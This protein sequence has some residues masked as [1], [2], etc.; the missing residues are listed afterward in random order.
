MLRRPQMCQQHLL[1]EAEASS[2]TQPCL[3][4][5][6]FCLVCIHIDTRAP[7]SS[8]MHECR[9]LCILATAWP[10]HVV[11]EVLNCASE[12][13]GTASARGR[14]Y[15]GVPGSV[16]PTWLSTFL[17]PIYDARNATNVTAGRYAFRKGLPMPLADARG[18]CHI[19]PRL[20]TAAKAAVS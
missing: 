20:H 15:V 2:H 14:S 4:A 12:A 7:M 10:C 6:L 13:L 17:A 8:L 18:G 16:L 19:T 5:P 9:C 1:T 3:P 11:I